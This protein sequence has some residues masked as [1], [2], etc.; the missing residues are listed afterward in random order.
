MI[1][2][3]LLACATTEEKQTCEQL[4]D[5]LV[6]TCEF[7]A[8]PSYESCAQGC[9]YQRSEGADMRGQLRCITNA[10]CDEFAILEC[11]HKF[12]AGESSEE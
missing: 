7:G 5:E 9:A 4:C 11:E 8:Y 12:G 6:Q 2:F 1:L 3:L 10:A